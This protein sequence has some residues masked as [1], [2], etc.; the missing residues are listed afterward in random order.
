[1]VDGNQLTVL[2]VDDEYSI[3]EALTELLLWR[4]Y[5]ILVAADGQQAL[6]MV[7]AQ[8]PDV[9]LTDMMMPR[10][11]GVQLIR[12]VWGDAGLA[13]LPMVLM[14]AAPASVPSDI[15]RRVTVVRKPFDLDASRRPCSA[16]RRGQL[17]PQLRRRW[18]TPAIAQPRGA[19]HP[20]ARRRSSSIVP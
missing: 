5:R 3:V 1:M 12:A 8:R 11:D 10:M 9:I 7:R 18:V 20:Q 6:Q 16:R 15:G 14:T 4:G 2:L 17:Q 13:D 19:P